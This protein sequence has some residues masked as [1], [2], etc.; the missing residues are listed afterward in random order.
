M[1]PAGRL[2]SIPSLE[3][4]FSRSIRDVAQEND[5]ESYARMHSTSFFFN[6]C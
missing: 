1:R 5:P 2:T 3:S 4:I 6:I